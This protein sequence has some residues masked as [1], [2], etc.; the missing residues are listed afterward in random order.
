MR[1]L[2]KLSIGLLFCV[3]VSGCGYGFILAVEDGDTAAVRA[4]LDAGADV[5]AELPI[6]GTRP[7]M[8]AAARGQLEI[9]RFLLD[10]GADVNVSDLTGW[11]PLHA[12]AYSGDPEIIRLLLDWGAVPTEETWY[13]PS[14]LTVAEQLE[15]THAVELLRAVQARPSGD[16]ITARRSSEPANEAPGRQPGASPN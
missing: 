5:N 1:S 7:L 13:L 6:L 14:P 12:A 4:K 11:T 3:L 15:R 8:A 2:S 10:R 16:S 9:V